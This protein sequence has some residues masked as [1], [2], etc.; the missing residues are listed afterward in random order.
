VWATEDESVVLVCADCLD[1]LSLIEAGSV[2]AV[3][4]DPPYSSGGA[5]RS[6]RNQSPSVKYTPNVQRAYAAFSGDNRDQRAYG[7]WCS[8]WLAGLLR[9]SRIGA[10]CSMFTDWRQLPTTTDAMQAGGWVWRGIAVWNKTEAARPAKGRFRNQ[11]EYIV[12]GSCGALGTE[13]G[14]S[15]DGIPCLPGLWTVPTAGMEKEHV[16]EKPESLLEGLVEICP[17]GGLVVDPF[18]GS[19]TTIV[20][21]VRLGRRAIGV[22]IDRKYFDIAVKRVEAELNRAPLFEPPPA[23]QKKLI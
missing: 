17:P 3:V 22:E 18:M 14:T 4:T 21:A 1:V 5:F 12:W 23:I 9:A 8:L 7:Y 13:V 6:D 15:T 2:G 19:G 10:T 16:A 20:A 11:C